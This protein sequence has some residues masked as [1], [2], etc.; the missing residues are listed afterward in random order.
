MS[1]PWAANDSFD[2]GR[3]RILFLMIMRRAAHTIIWE[4][5]LH[6]QVALLER[7][8]YRRHQK[9]LLEEIFINNR[10]DGEFRN[11]NFTLDL[12]DFL[13]SYLLAEPGRLPSIRKHKVPSILEPAPERTN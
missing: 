7:Q 9:A 8:E 2:S 12:Q 11:S 3:G 4:I 10:R 5:L 13:N 6:A 1:R